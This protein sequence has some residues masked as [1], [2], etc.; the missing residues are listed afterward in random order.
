MVIRVKK[1]DDVRITRNDYTYTTSE[2]AAKGMLNFFRLLDI[3]VVEARGLSREEAE[4]YVDLME[5]LRK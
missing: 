2:S 4:E 3:E 5:A 1:V